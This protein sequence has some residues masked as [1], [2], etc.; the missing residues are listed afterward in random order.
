MINGELAHLVYKT[1]IQKT[2]YWVPISALTD[3]IRGLWNLYVIIP[4]NPSDLDNTFNIERRD[5]E[6]IYTK[7]ELAYIQGAISI[8]EDYVSQGL[9]KLVVGQQVKRNTTVAAR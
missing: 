8:N 5:I 4:T 7:G 1:H 6:I 3:G 9:H 2:G